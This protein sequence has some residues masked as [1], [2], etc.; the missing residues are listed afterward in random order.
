E[1]RA[2]Q[3]KLEQ[4]RNERKKTLASLES[5]IQQGQQQLSEMRANESRLRGRIAQAAAAAKA[6]ADREARE[7]QDVPDRQQEASRKGTTY[8]PTERERSL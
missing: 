7:A 2:Q 6:R 4:A 5:S 3:S 1:Q 8:K